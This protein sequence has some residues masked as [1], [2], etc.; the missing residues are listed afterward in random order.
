M[1]DASP[2]GTIEVTYGFW[3]H[4]EVYERPMIALSCGD[5]VPA[6]NGF[7]PED[8]GRVDICLTQNGTEEC[9]HI[10]MAE[11]CEEEFVPEPGSFV[12]LG[13]GLVGL[14]GYATLRWRTRE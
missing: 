3:C 13:S 8:F 14:A 9:T 10:E 6:I 7:V 12:L 11:I 1:G 4:G 5:V 2:G